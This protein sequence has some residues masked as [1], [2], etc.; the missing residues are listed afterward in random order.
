MWDHVAESMKGYER[1][2]SMSKLQGNP[3][4]QLFSTSRA[5]MLVRGRV[6]LKAGLID[7]VPQLH[8]VALVT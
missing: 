6:T 1:H 5:P 3:L 8:P 4:A 7:Q 2:M